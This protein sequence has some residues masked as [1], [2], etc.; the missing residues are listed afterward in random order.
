MWEILII[1]FSNLTLFV[2]FVIALF[3]GVWPFAGASF[4]AAMASTLYHDVYFKDHVQYYLSLN[5]TVSEFGSSVIPWVVNTRTQLSMLLFDYAFSNLIQ[6]FAVVYLAPKN[7]QKF[8]YVVIVLSWIM[9]VV[10]AT[11]AGNL[12]A[13]TIF[14]EH[15]IWISAIMFVYFVCIYMLFFIT[16]VW[17]TPYKQWWPHF[18]AYYNTNFRTWLL[19]LSLGIALLGIIS[20]LVVQNLF[21]STYFVAHPIW[22]VCSSIGQCGFLLSIKPEST[23]RPQP[24]T[25]DHKIPRIY[26]NTRSYKVKDTETNKTLFTV[27]YANDTGISKF[28]SSVLPN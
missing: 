20:W 28:R 5:Y 10:V 15:T 24:T 19:L 4:G 2:P 16:Y 14:P 1:S 3:I 22:H 25:F 27:H 26:T 7:S 17:N 9:W 12:L 6:I 11:L 13:T 23:I 18:R 8:T 21:P